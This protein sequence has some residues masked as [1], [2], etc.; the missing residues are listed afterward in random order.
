LAKTG[1]PN[2]VY[3]ILS[4]WRVGFHKWGLTGNHSGGSFDATDAQTFMTGAASPFALSFAPFINPL[5]P[6]SG[7]GQSNTV[8]RAAYYDGINS[9]PVWEASYDSVTPAPTHLQPLGTAW[10]HIGSA[11]VNDALEVCVVIEARVGTSVKNKPVF[12]RKYIHGVPTGNI[13]VNTEGLPIY[14]FASE[15]T[16]AAQAMGDGSWFGSRVY[17]SP[18]GSQAPAASYVPLESPGNHQMPRGRKRKTAAVA[19]G[20]SALLSLLEQGLESGAIALA[21]SL[22]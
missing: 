9:A 18:K 6:S 8:V 3:E 16:T 19:S 5:V 14:E 2:F 4:P 20:Q 12:V 10:Q 13:N 22:L 15:A 21:G 1:H 17:V 7:G 11:I